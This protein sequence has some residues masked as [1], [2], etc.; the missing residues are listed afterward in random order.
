M[1]KNNIKDWK[2]MSRADTIV[3]EL[4]NDIENISLKHSEIPSKVIIKTK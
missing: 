1:I 3:R 4:E 2:R